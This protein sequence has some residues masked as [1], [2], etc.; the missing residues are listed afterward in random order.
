MKNQY[1][2]IDM[3]FRNE[4]EAVVRT[5]VHFLDKQPDM[6][7][8]CEVWNEDSHCMEYHF[9][10]HMGETCSGISEKTFPVAGENCFTANAAVIWIDGAGRLN[11]YDSGKD[12]PV[13]Q[14]ETIPATVSVTKPRAKNK[15]ETRVY[16]YRKGDCD[17]FYPDNGVYGGKF[18]TLMPFAGMVTI[19]SEEWDIIGIADGAV[20]GYPAPEIVMFLNAGGSVNYERQ[21]IPQ[22]KIVDKKHIS[23]DL[24]DDW[25]CKL[26]SSRILSDSVLDFFGKFYIRLQNTID[27]NLYRFAGIT[28]TSMKYTASEEEKL[29]S[30]EPIRLFYGCMARD[31][32]IMMA[33]GN[34]KGI[35]EIKI[36]RAHV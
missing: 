5:H 28:V 21:I 24:N 15:K 7:V 29:I 18:K 34:E 33:D 9:S 17:Y 14:K 4:G 23:W 32:R 20:P 10:E 30:I 31:T 26:D 22:L 11:L 13:Y 27:P 1:F 2:N 12:L 25:N 6:V 19:D 16:Y 8:K 36:G 35:S 3:S